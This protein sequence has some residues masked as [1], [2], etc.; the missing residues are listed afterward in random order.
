MIGQ[1]NTTSKKKNIA[2]RLIKSFQIICCAPN[3]ISK[4]L[5]EINPE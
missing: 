3:N 5:E 1:S 4:G 2:S